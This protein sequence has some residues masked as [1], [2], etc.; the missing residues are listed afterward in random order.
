MPMQLVIH[1]QK[2]GKNICP[3]HRQYPGDN[4]RQAAHG[5]FHFPHLH[6]LC[7]SDCVGGRADGNPFC[8]RVI[9]RKSVV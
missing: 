2:I 6:G 7:R 9:D 8:H 3:N 4:D 5:A 1:L